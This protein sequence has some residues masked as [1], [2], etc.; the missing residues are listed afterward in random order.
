MENLDFDTMPSI[1]LNII[2][3]KT[4][5]NEDGKSVLDFYVKENL[6]NR[7]P[8]DFWVDDHTCQIRL[9]R[10]I[11]QCDTIIYEAPIIDEVTPH[12]INT[13]LIFE[14]ISLVSK[15]NTNNAR[16]LIYI[17]YK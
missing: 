1:G 16:F 3:T 13:S 11:N 8:H 7:E 17:W 14:D 9:T 4:V 5:R 12:P 2:T 6:G 10:L 15:Y